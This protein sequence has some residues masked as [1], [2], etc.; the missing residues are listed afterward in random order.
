MY[1][2]WLNEFIL[3]DGGISIVSG[4]ICFIQNVY[5]HCTVSGLYAILVNPIFYSH[6]DS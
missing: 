3:M 4:Q 5:A 2:M 1:D 6:A